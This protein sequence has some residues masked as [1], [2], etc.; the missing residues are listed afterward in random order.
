MRKN[1]FEIDEPKLEGDYVIVKRDLYD[2]LDILEDADIR[3]KKIA[4][5]IADLE[6]NVKGGAICDISNL[7]RQINDIIKCNQYNYEHLAGRYMGKIREI[8][9][10]DPICSEYEGDE[11]AGMNLPKGREN[12]HR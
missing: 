9:R 10:R 6:K 1:I 5:F 12:D 8:K 2:M 7:V 4:S 3:F 11:N